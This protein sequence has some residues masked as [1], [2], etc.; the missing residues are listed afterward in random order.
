MAHSMSKDSL[1]SWAISTDFSCTNDSSVFIQYLHLFWTCRGF[2]RIPNLT[3]STL[4]LENNPF[5]LVKLQMSN[6]KSFHWNFKDLV[7]PTRPLKTFKPSIR[8][9]QRQLD[10]LG[11]GLRR[12][13]FQGLQPGTGILRS[14]AGASL[15][16]PL[17]QPSKSWSCLWVFNKRFGFF[18]AV[19]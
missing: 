13:A 15:C 17:C 19:K 1:S 12:D 4:C 8:G 7:L 5:L 18:T 2:L 14:V 3:S 9:G 16:I 10:R 6:V 11:Q